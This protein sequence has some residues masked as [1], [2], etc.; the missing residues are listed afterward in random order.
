[1]RVPTRLTYPFPF[2]ELLANGADILPSFLLHEL[3]VG[4]QLGSIV[5]YPIRG[6]APCFF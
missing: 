5:R 6:G 1:M 3:D 2:P 4:E